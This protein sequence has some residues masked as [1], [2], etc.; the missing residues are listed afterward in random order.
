MNQ[1]TSLSNAAK[2]NVAGLVLTATGM[3]LERGAGSTLYPTL[4]G[5]I[6]LVLVA[7]FVALRPGRWTGYVGLIVPLV[8]AAGLIVS[9]A[10]SPTFLDQLTRIGN[11]G[12]FVGS[13]LHVVGLMAA[14]AGGIGIVVR[15]QANPTATLDGVG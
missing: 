5:P 3:A 10:L 14:V 11:A 9:A 6:V 8:L 12:V 4:T 1:L 7:V 2:L 15:H 13:V